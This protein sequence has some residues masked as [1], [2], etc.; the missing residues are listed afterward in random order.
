ML[1]ISSFFMHTCRIRFLSIIIIIILLHDVLAC[2]KKSYTQPHNT[3]SCCLIFYLL[4]S[5]LTY[6]AS[7]VEGWHWFTYLWSRLVRILRYP[8]VASSVYH[9]GCRIR[10][11]RCL[12]DMFDSL[13]EWIQGQVRGRR[14]R[15]DREIYICIYI[16]GYGYWW[17]CITLQAQKHHQQEQNHTIIS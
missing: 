15:K 6:R 1:C 7:N 12:Q 9:H 3:S 13:W 5:F 11:R 8:F 2:C 10:A 4:F 14:K 17:I 16:D